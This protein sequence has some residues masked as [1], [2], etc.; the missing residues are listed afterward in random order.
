MINEY[1]GNQVKKSI[2]VKQKLIDSQ[3][4]MDLI[5]EVS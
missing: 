2:D 5:Q 4:L 1:I 3:E